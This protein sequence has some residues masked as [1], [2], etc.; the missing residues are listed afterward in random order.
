MQ[1]N[2]YTE[3]MRISTAWLYDRPITENIVANIGDLADNNP[4]MKVY[5][6]CG[7]TQC[8]REVAAL[9]KENVVVGFAVMSDIVKG[10]PLERWVAHHPINKLLAGQEFENHLHEVAILGILWQY[11]G[12]YV[13]PMVK[14][15]KASLYHHSLCVVRTVP[16]E[17][18]PRSVFDVSFFLKKHPFINDIAE[19]YATHYLSSRERT[20]FCAGPAWDYLQNDCS[21]SPCKGC[22]RLQETERPKSY[23]VLS[24]SLSATNLG[25]YSDDDMENIV[26]AQYLPFVNTVIDRRNA[27]S[28]KKVTSFFNGNW[29]MP[30]E[31]GF[32][33]ETID[34]IVLSV[35]LKN[36][37]EQ[38]WMKKLLTAKEPIGCRDAGSEQYLRSKGV[39]TFL[40]SSL[41]LLMNNP[42]S[43]SQTR[44]H[45]YLV[46][47]KE[48]LVDLLPLQVQE[49]AI[50]LRPQIQKYTTLSLASYQVAAYQLLEILGSAKLVVTEN[51]QLAFTCVAMDT[52]VIYIYNGNSNS[53]NSL[54]HTIDRHMMTEEQ[55]RKWFQN[56][57]WDSIP[58]NPNPAMLMRLRATS[59][60]II[61]QNQHLY[62]TAVRFGAVPMTPPLSLQAEKILSFYLVFSTSEEAS[63]EVYDGSKK[64]QPGK[65]NW[66]HWR[67]VESI[68]YHH[69]NAEVNIY[70]N[71][72]PGDIFN[73]LTEA[74]Y[75]IQVKRYSLEDMLIGSPAEGFIEKLKEARKG[76]F[77]YSHETDLLRMFLLYTYG[78]IYM[79][80][81][82]IVVRPLNSLKANVARI[83]DADPN[84]GCAFLKFEKGSPFLKACLKDYAEKYSSKVWG[85]NGPMLLTR[86]YGRSQWSSDVVN[87]ANYKQFFMIYWKKMNKECFIDTK[88]RVYDAHMQVLRTEAFV[89]HLN[90]K[91]SGN[92]GVAGDPIKEG[93]IC[94]HLLNS[95][96]ILCD[97]TH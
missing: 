73:V 9:E 70:S 97:Q 47:L 67:S 92:K 55:A 32:S 62:D 38:S 59:W 69:P 71:T 33:L 37:M 28:V 40:S 87:V 2:N 89:V 29:K 66:R 31:N 22:T 64:K 90:S 36:G 58:Q 50:D 23:G 5:V 56:F 45:I 49:S 57:P 72:L 25:D 68:F 83:T 79:D 94:K 78:G 48:E 60:N 91:I 7:T 88:G 11:G 16:Q 44:S 74:G 75:S 18:L 8:V 15:M 85:H 30:G 10:T 43:V 95:Y 63:L 76:P 27:H 34:P 35:S 80:T 20:P 13:N 1:N 24:H 3:S 39:Q 61:R 4:S 81:D 6:Y 26:A 54:T 19:E 21:V 46:E 53:T 86:V 77:W 51:H 12:Y 41:M 65:F 14:T 84:I 82:V 52:P 17:C 42:S 96:C 93:T